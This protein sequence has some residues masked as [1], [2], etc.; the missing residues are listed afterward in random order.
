MN[1]TYFAL[2]MEYE[3]ADILLSDCCEKYFGVELRS[4]ERL[5]RQQRLPVP[6]FRGGSQKS[7]WMVDASD[8]ANWLDMLKE[9]ARRAHNAA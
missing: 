6:C 8:L 1:T 2:V 3:T 5:A 7:K 9:E 4:A